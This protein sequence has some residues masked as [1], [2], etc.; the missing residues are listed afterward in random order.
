MKIRPKPEVIL[1]EDGDRAWRMEPGGARFVFGSHEHA[2][3][4]A[5]RYARYIALP[6]WRRRLVD[7]AYR[8]VGWVEA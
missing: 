5:A 2:R 4:D 6:R 8:V 3:R 7:I 1:T